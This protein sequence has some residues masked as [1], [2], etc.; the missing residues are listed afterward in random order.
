[1]PQGTWSAWIP[2]RGRQ[3]GVVLVLR[4]RERGV[5][6]KNQVHGAPILETTIAQNRLSV[7]TVARGT[8]HVHVVIPPPNP[9]RAVFATEYRAQSPFQ[10]GTGQRAAYC[11]G[12]RKLGRG[13]RISVQNGNFTARYWSKGSDDTITGMVDLGFTG[14]SQGCSSKP[15]KTG[16]QSST[17]SMHR[18]YYLSIDCQRNDT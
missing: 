18:A 13:T 11:D 6:R 12:S 9:L 10:F 4:T 5:V 8:R 3:R 15:L 2:S 17:Y 7:H 14:M 16:S 1:M